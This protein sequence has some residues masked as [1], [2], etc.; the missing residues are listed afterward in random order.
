MEEIR[1]LMDLKNN[2][3]NMYGTCRC[4]SFVL[5]VSAG[6]SDHSRYVPAGVSSLTSITVSLLSFV[7][8]TL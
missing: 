4:L 1:A 8:Y 6:S 3:R 2:I 7:P 5:A